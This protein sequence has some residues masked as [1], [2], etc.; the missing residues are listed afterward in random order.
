MT[1]S[2]DLKNT[3]VLPLVSRHSSTIFTGT[4]ATPGVPGTPPW[5]LQGDICQQ[6]EGYPQCTFT[7]GSCW[8]LNQDC[9]HDATQLLPADFRNLPNG[10]P[11]G[12][13]GR[14]TYTVDDEPVNGQ[15][16]KKVTIK[17]A[18]D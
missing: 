8:A 17:I 3:T 12:R 18:W 7:P 10:T 5:Y 13:K 16:L 14:M 6:R 2:A 11:P 15:V 1:R 4:V 9:L